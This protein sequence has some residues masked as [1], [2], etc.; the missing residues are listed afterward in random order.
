MDKDK[1]DMMVEMTRDHCTGEGGIEILLT[2][3]PR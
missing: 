1:F 2:A 3:A